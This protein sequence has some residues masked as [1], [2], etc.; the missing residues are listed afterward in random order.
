MFAGI[1]AA[2]PLEKSTM[3]PRVIDLIIPSKNPKEKHAM[4]TR[5]ITGMLLAILG[6]FAV[7]ASQTFDPT[8]LS[9]IA[10][11]VG[12]STVVISVLAQLDRSRAA[13]QRAL[14]AAL[15]VVG[16]VMLVLALTVSGTAV[17]WLSFGLALGIAA[18]AVC[19]LTLHEIS[20]WRGTHQLS[21]LRGL[22]EDQPAAALIDRG[23]SR[24]A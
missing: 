15:V 14:D 20:T 17:T 4:S 24:A 16:V 21:Q 9:W 5:Y 12:A 2:V 13:V 18:L 8:T 1:A 6:G 10:F 19:G 7:V 3:R 22:P 11:A 23:G